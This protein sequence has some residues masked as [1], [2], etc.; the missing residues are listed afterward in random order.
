MGALTAADAGGRQLVFVQT[1]QAH[2]GNGSRVDLIVIVYGQKIGNV[3]THRTAVAAVS[4]GGAGDTGLHA[5]GNVQQGGSFFFTQRPVCL[6]CIQVVFN[7]SDFIH[8]GQNDLDIGQI[9][10]E[11][12]CIGRIAGIFIKCLQACRLF[13]VQIGKFAAAAGLHDPDTETV[14][15]NDVIFLLGVLQC[16]VKIVALDLYKFKD[17]FMPA[18]EF[19]Q[20]F[21]TAVE[22]EAEMADLSFFLHFYDIRNDVVLIALID[23]YRP[24]GN[25]VKQVEIEIIGP[26]LLQ[27]Q[28]EQGDV[29]DRSRQGMAGELVGDIIALTRI[30]FQCFR[31]C[32]F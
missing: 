30:F 6:K 23:L 4:A 19:F 27:R 32:D 5:F 11:A 20:Q 31:H 1:V 15:G 12:E 16:P 21:R 10:Q 18:Q 13:F 9:L 26:A 24:F 29:V 8:A 22:G 28:I 2:A 25:V 3:Q 14:C 7:L 17:T